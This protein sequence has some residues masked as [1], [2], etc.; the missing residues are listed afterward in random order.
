MRRIDPL[1][2]KYYDLRNNG[3]FLDSYESSLFQ[4][5][6][7]GDKRYLY[8]YWD[9]CEDSWYDRRYHPITFYGKES[10]N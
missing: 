8:K 4:Y 9:E 10:I 6:Q 7:T 1:S 2:S 3:Q 5:Y